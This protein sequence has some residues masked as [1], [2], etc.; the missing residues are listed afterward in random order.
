M[1]ANRLSKELSELESHAGAVFSV[2]AF[3]QVP[4]QLTVDELA[5]RRFAFIQ[6]RV[7]EIDGGGEGHLNLKIQAA[8]F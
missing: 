3:K 8:L 5:Q 7:K 6:S 2:L 1:L 4:E